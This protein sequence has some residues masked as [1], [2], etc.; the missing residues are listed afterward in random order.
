MTPKLKLYVWK[1]YDGERWLFQLGVPG[2]KCP[3]MLLGNEKQ[4]TI[5]SAHTHGQAIVQGLALLDSE[6]VSR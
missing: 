4:R 3:D 2:R 6:L 5:R 1:S